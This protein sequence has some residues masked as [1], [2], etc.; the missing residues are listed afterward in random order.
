MNDQEKRA[1][2]L[3]FESIVVDAHA[4]TIGRV[5]DG[6][7]DLTRRTRGHIDVPKM[8]AGGLDA[9]FFAFWIEPKHVERGM[10]LRRTLDMMD[11]LRSVEARSKGRFVVATTADAVRRAA[12]RRV[13]AGVPC[14]EGGHAIE[15]DLAVV[16]EFG[17]LGIRYMTLTWNNSTDWADAAAEKPRHNGLTRFG[18]DVVREMNRAGIMVDLSHVHEKT[19]WAA[20]GTTRKPVIVSHSCARALC[21]HRRNLWDPQLKA[22]AK[23]AGVV[24]INYY[25]CFISQPFKERTDAMWDERDAEERGIR[26]RVKDRAKLEPA[27][28]RI[29]D[30]YERIEHGLPRPA[31]GV[32]LDH[33][34]HVARVAGVDHVGLGSDF[35][36]VASLPREIDDCSMLPR[37][38]RGLLERGH[39]AAAVKKILGGNVLRVMEYNEG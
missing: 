39:S 37:V 35:D 34:D 12:S 6:G 38:T 31:F 14:I 7:E 8:R 16:R 5:V 25:S 24:C 15:N 20:I 32:L 18:R 4:D 17:R 33:I 19:F 9:Q 36:G 1:R 3:H 23:N 29:H 22:V 28:K 30:R 10:S 13:P 11:A 27:L 21:N 26:R 2:E